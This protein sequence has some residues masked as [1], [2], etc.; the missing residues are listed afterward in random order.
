MAA[1]RQVSANFLE[2]EQHARVSQRVGLHAVEVEEL[3]D[4]V[5][6]RAQQLSVNLGGHRRAADFGEAVTAEEVHRKGQHEYTRYADPASAVE[7]VVDDQVP[8]ARAAQALVN[9]DGAQFGEILPHNVQG[10][11]SDDAAAV[12]TLGHAELEDVLV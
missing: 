8:D 2:P 5:I 4:A 1:K 10:P 11:A 9:G 3:G 7:Q 6:V 12:G